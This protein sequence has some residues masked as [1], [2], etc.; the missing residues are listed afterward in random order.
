MTITQEQKDAIRNLVTYQI[1]SERL[2][3]E[4]H[5]ATMFDVDGDDM[6]DKELVEFCEQ[7]NVEHIW[8]SLYKLSK[9]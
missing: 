4:E 1:E 6:D 2:H 7:N 8:L 9:I 3:I 5:L